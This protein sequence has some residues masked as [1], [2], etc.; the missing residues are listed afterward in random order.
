MPGTHEDFCSTV[1]DNMFE[2]VYYVDRKRRI[3]HWNAAAERMT[4]YTRHEVEG[5]V[6][7]DNI[8]RHI[9]TDGTPI[10][11]NGCPLQKAME[12]GE[13]REAE[14]F[15]HHRAGHRVPVHVRVTPIR[16][17]SGEVVGALELFAK[18]KEEETQEDLINALE[19]LAYIDELTDLPNRRF[20]KINI[21]TRYEEFKRYGW[22]FGILFIDIDHF[23]DVNDAHGHDVGDAVLQMVGSTLKANTRP[24]DHIGRW[25]GE[26]FV[27]VATRVDLD[28]LAQIA[29]RFLFLVAA[30]TLDKP[31]KIN[32]TISIGAA[33]AQENESM[34]DLI[35]R[36]DEKLYQAKEGGRNRVEI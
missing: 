35:K 33:M 13:V 1:L 28:T 18:S 26:E 22:P 27:A 16:D 17:E 5:R 15:F 9:S 25:G 32:V 36:A 29:Q 2:A 30:S 4:G 10:C 3:M 23:K 19:N 20:T 34:E 8:L 31:E 14:V 7:A 12:T 11:H 24:F 6:C 21:E